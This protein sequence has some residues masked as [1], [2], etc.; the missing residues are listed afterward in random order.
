MRY[1]LSDAGDA[2]DDHL[3]A[4]M[5]CFCEN[6]LCRDQPLYGI[7][8]TQQILAVAAVSLPDRIPQSPELKKIQARLSRLLGKAAVNRLA[9]YDDLVFA[10]EPDRSHHYLGCSALEKTFKVVDWGVHLLSTSSI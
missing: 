4:M 1:G 6:R 10:G 8:D 5:D 3:R 9:K 2:Y 7:R